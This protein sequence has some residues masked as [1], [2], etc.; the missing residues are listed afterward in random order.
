[1]RFDAYLWIPR[2]AAYVRRAD[3]PTVECILCCI[4]DGDARV[5][6]LEVWRDET[7]I[8]VLNLY[9]Y[10][11]GHLMVFPR[12][13][14]VEL[15]ELGEEEAL[16][17]FGSMNLAVRALKS[18]YSPKGYNIGFNIGEVSGASI[19][20]LHAHIVPRY[21]NELGFIDIIGGAKVLIENPPE[22]VEKLSRAFEKAQREVEG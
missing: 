14:V 6:S 20:H 19:P 16:S 11:P 21:G 1:M 3:K 17:L 22:Y 2:K 5:K 18:C 7:S 9:P 12:R 10:N 13:H 15:C 8:A 4:R